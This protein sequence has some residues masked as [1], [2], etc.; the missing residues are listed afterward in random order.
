MRS[1]IERE[2]DGRMKENVRRETVKTRERGTAN[3]SK[4]PLLFFK[5]PTT[6][7]TTSC[8]NKCRIRETCA[9]ENKLYEI[10]F[11]IFADESETAI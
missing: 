6:T 5:K 2:R 1:R 9:N 3:N 4:S 7:T 8:N 11:Y 10:P